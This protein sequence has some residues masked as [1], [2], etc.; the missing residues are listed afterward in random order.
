MTE[1]HSFPPIAAT[2]ATR[3][4]LGTMPSVASLAAGEYYAHGRNAF[5]PLM[6]EL[7][8]LPPAADY[9]SR[10]QALIR[11]RIALWDVLFACNRPGSLDSAIERASMQPNDFAGFFRL[12]PHIRQVYFN[13]KQAAAIW[14]QHVAPRLTGRK[15]P[16]ELCVLPSTSAANAS[17]SLAE[18]QKRW[19]IV[20]QLPELGA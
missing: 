2:D 6:S 18:K 3:L 7:L 17:L 10:C 11:H 12:Y 4:I 9:A 13:G 19:H 8:A 5:W 15:Q 16:L 14:Q 1:V 20:R